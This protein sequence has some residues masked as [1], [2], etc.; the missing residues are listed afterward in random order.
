MR[1]AVTGPNGRLASWLIAHHGCLPLECDISDFD[2]TRVELQRV[3][4]DVVINA[5]AYTD[6]DQAEKE[7]DKALL[8]NLRGAGN[9]RI[10][11]RGYLIHIS[12]PYVFNGEKDSSYI[13]NDEVS[14]INHY[15]WS[16]WGGEAAMATRPDTTLI[17]RTISL[18]GPGPKTDF[19][20]QVVQ[21][22]KDGAR[23]VM[24]EDLLSNP[25]YIPHLSE[26]LMHIIN[27]KKRPAGI[28]H[29]AGTTRVSRAGWAKEIAKAYGFDQHAISA[30]PYDLSGTPR[31][32]RA[33][34]AVRKA[35]SLGVPLFSLREGLR[36]L[37]HGSS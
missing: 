2:A 21:A 23:I 9:V 20:K 3:E 33:T 7:K 5:A 36:D 29:V 24:P 14:P 32:K 17:V 15:G 37:R 16:K 1:V 10:A 18:Y 35:K 25:T 11:H 19:V 12:T 34:V 31:P 28:L 27:M 26:A 8:V 30:K 4:P 22:L 13:E 6:V